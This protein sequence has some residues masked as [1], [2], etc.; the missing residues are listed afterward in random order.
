MRDLVAFVVWC[1]GPFY[2]L[3]GLVGLIGLWF[4]RR[5]DDIQLRD[6]ITGEPLGMTRKQFQRYKL[7][8][9][10]KDEKR[11]AA[12]VREVQL[13]KQQI[14]A[15]DW[16]SPIM[17]GLLLWCCPPAHAAD[18]PQVSQARAAFTD[19]KAAYQ[20][21][22][23]HLAAQNFLEAYTKAHLPVLLYDAALAECYQG[24]PY[25]GRE[26]LRRFFRVIDDVKGP[27]D[28]DRFAVER[29]SISLLIEIS[30]DHN[31]DPEKNLNTPPER[32]LGPNW[33]TDRPCSH[34]NP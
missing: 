27:T 28:I 32:Y 3:T 18:T 26:I 14:K 9:G 5:R 8:L 19:A 12:A 31:I 17:M 2:G 29:L 11:I 7:A 16:S 4:D 10:T 6:A 33:R 20:V 24:N 30:W 23:F 15:R 22:Q 34:W 25:Y 1:V 21:G 13:R